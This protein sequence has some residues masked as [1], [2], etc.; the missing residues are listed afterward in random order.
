M[1]KD[2]PAVAG[3]IN[4]RLEQLEMTQ[5]EL[6]KRSRVSPATLRQMQHAVAKQYNP[7]TLSSIS[8]ALGWP[9]NHLERVAD[10]QSGKGRD[11]LTQL[12]VAVSELSERVAA[13]ERG[14]TR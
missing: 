8:E 5:T 3:A 10:G 12:E 4:T 1:A 14:T 9:S 11:R 13:L 2:W 7:R 6:A